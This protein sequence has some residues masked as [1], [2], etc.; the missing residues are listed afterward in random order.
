M[1]EQVV[2]WS[3]VHLVVWSLVSSGVDFPYDLPTNE[4]SELAVHYNIIAPTISSP[5]P[6]IDSINYT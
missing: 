6:P 1:G 3:C 2:V 4:P 5:L